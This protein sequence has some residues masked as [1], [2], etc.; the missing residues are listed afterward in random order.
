MAISQKNRGR[1]E[2][3][4]NKHP[5]WSVTR[6]GN[7]LKGVDNDDIRR[8]MAERAGKGE[9][10]EEGGDGN[11]AS[12]SLK[13]RSVSDIIAPHD[14]VGK[15]LALIS[16]IPRGEVMEDDMFRKELVVGDS[17]WRRAKGSTRLSGFWYVMPDKSMVWGQ[18]AT[19]SMVAEK[20]KDI[21]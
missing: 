19:I 20:M 7:S 2:C 4:L 21:M 11:D 13:T 17:K 6:H 16:K 12:T 14:I 18:K 10:G 9:E 1:V 8:I 3:S 15:A 5:E